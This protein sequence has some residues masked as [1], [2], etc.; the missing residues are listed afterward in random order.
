[1]PYSPPAGNAALFNFTTGAYAPPAGAA[2]TF[3]FGGGGP[4][5]PPPP[6]PQLPTALR[7]ARQHEDDWFFSRSSRFAPIASGGPIPFRRPWQFQPIE[8][9]WMPAR[10]SISFVPSAARKRR[11]PLFTIV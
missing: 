10:R 5:P 7:Q 6:Q 9:D 3:N 11:R 8:D 2:V 4:P 1:M